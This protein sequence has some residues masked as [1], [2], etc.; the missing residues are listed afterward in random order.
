MA[1]T[2]YQY[3]LKGD[4]AIVYNA[5]GERELVLPLEFRVETMPS[6][7][8]TSYRNVELHFLMNFVGENAPAL[9][10]FEV[11]FPVQPKVDVY[12]GYNGIWYMELAK[13]A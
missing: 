7:I 2:S 5:S 11:I 6:E 9:S 1:K 4:T 10:A 8:Y 3:T 13:N 12:I